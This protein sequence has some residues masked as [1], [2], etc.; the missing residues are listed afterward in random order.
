MGQA[1]PEQLPQTCNIGFQYNWFERGGGGEG[2]VSV[3]LGNGFQMLVSDSAV[4]AGTSLGVVSVPEPT[5]VVLA[6]LAAVGVLG[7]LR[8]RR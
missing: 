1:S 5:T 6:G 4:G 3:N 7:M 2:D 8:R